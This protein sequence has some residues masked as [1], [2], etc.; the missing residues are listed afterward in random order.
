[1]ARG[2]RH[3]RRRQSSSCSLRFPTDSVNLLQSHSNPR[4]SYYLPKGVGDYHFGVSLSRR[5]YSAHANVSYCRS[6][7]R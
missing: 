6:G 7:T 2:E 4:V 5:S 3:R 1:M